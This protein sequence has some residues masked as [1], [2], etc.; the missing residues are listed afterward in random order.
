MRIQ[1]E[2]QGE[3]ENEFV[4]IEQELSGGEK[5]KRGERLCRGMGL[6]VVRTG[7]PGLTCLSA[8]GTIDAILKQ[9]ANFEA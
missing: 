7:E 8:N 5:R 2:L 6:L 9:I 3:D 1:R 4:K